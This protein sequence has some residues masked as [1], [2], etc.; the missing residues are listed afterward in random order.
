MTRIK[1][2]I[3]IGNSVTT[4]MSAHPLYLVWGGI[5]RRCCE[6]TFKCYDIY[7]GR[8]IRVCKAWLNSFESFYK[9]AISNGWEKGL[10]VDRRNGNGNYTPKNCRIVTQKVNANNKRNTKYYEIN[11]IRK[12]FTEWCELYHLSSKVVSKRL[13]RGHPLSVALKKNLPPLTANQSKKRVKLIDLMSGQET[14]FDSISTCAAFLKVDGSNITY[15][16]KSYGTIKKRYKVI[17]LEFL[18][19]RDG[20]KSKKSA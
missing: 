15:A 20:K 12:P 19:N 2:E 10:H 17:F 6:P 16:I 3:K 13:K 9:W 11:G 5:K 18:I 14:E 8:G 1:K 4:R 7:G